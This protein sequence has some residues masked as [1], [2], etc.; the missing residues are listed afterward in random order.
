M[1]NKLTT[2]DQLVSPLTFLGR[3]YGD[4]DYVKVSVGLI[5]S[6]FKSKEPSQYVADYAKY[7]PI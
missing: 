2:F 6:A 1:E 5:Q 3:G 4:D 7:F